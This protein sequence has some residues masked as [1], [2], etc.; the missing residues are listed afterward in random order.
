METREASGAQGS[1]GGVGGGIG[2]L[3][4][5]DQ[6]SLLVWDGGDT[7]LLLLKPRKS[8]VDQDVW[9]PEPRMAPWESHGRWLSCEAS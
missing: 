2:P 9:A 1:R 7:G 8:W 4:V 5:D 3:K 6:P